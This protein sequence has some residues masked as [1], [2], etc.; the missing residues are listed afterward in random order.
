MPGIVL[1]RR[2]WAVGS[3]D[4]V[5]ASVFLTMLHLLWLVTNLVNQRLLF[6]ILSY[7]L[8]FL[9][10]ILIAHTLHSIIESFNCI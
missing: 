3:D 4:M 6:I 9:M 1:F 10:D 5:V 8:V 7:Y 2:R